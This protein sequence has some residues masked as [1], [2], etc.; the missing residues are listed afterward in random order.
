VRTDPPRRLDL[1]EP[2]FFTIRR[3][4]GG[5]EI[6]CE[7]RLETGRDPYTGEEMDRSPRLVPYV[8]G[9]AMTGEDMTEWVDRIWLGRPVG[10]VRFRYLLAV[11]EWA[12]KEAPAAPEANYGRAVDLSRSPSLF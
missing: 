11:R 10:E 7:L 1:P 5:P 2:G 12:V 8:A 6:P 3:I 9:E 4:K